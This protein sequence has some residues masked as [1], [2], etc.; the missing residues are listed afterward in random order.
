[1][2]ALSVVRYTDDYKARG[3]DW[4]SAESPKLFWNEEDAL[5]AK[6]KL[7][8]ERIVDAIEEE[9]DDAIEDEDVMNA[10]KKNLPVYDVLEGWEFSKLNEFFV[11]IT[12][13][14]YVPRSVSIAVER[15]EVK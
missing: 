1:M 3:D 5:N 15:L 9:E 2:W 14:Y 11:R 7:I 10:L 12:Q 8:I 4:S 6:R 13:G